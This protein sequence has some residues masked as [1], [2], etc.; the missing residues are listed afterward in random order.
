MHKTGNQVTEESASERLD[1]VHLMMYFHLNPS[2]LWPKITVE[3]NCKNVFLLKQ[4]LLW[5]QVNIQSSVEV[6]AVPTDHDISRQ[7]GPA[8]ANDYLKPHLHH[9]YASQWSLQKKERRGPGGAGSRVEYVGD[10][11]CLWA[12]FILKDTSIATPA[13]YWGVWKTQYSTAECFRIFLAFRVF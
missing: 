11:S 8:P 6:P 10:S 13:K 7:A 2:N 12:N 3:S 1:Q 4:Y 5:S 9:H